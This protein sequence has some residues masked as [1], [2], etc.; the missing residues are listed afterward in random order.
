MILRWLFMNEISLNHRIF[1]ISFDIQLHR[2]KVMTRELNVLVD[3]Q[4]SF[5]STTSKSNANH[6]GNTQFESTSLSK[7]QQ[8]KDIDYLK[9]IFD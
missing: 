5:S 6:S 2:L 7:Y 1:V 3:D 8:G 4:S 9:M